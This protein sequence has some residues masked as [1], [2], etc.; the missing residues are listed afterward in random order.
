MKTIKGPAIFLAQFMGN[1]KPFNNLKDIANWASSLGYK[2]VQIPAWE[3]RL[4]N[5]DLASESKTYCEGL[6]GVL[7]E[8]NLEL[9]ELSSH[10]QGQLVAVNP[11]YDKQFD[12]FAPKSVRNNPK[13]RQA[14]ATDQLIKCAK[15]SRNLGIE[16]HGT[17]S[18]SLMWHMAHPWPQIPNGLTN[19]AFEELAKLWTP[20]LNVFDEQ[21]VDVCYEIHPGEDLHDG[22][23]FERFLEATHN[24]KRV[25][26]LYDPSHFVLQ[27]LDYIS[28]IDI[29]HQYIKMFHVK[30]AEFNPTGKSGTFGG[31]Q[32]W[33][34]RAG[35]YRS[36]GDGQIDF[37]TVFSKLTQYN[38]D[39]WAVM[40]WECCIKSPEQGALEGS[41]FIKSHIIETTDKRFDDFAGQSVEENY[42]KSLLGI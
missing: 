10:L 8:H 30:D 24:H 7:D 36:L 14:W 20:I 40:E 2:G 9:T 18:G 5:L 12:C 34:D 41:D 26:I 39:L 11:A 37:Q 19:L 13:K 15:A 38:L 29:Y 31:Y 6:L 42:L 33:K 27:Q 23:T 25:N 21:G 35:R 3:D 32:D 17:F 28:Y 22:V 1:E 4:I 16:V